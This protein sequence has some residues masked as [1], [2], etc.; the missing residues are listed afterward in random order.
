LIACPFAEISEFYSTS[1]KEP[2]G[3]LRA[4]SSNAVTGLLLL[5]FVASI[6]V[7]CESRAMLLFP[8]S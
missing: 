6:I 8:L 3:I 4:M 5:V 2:K 7:H 1:M